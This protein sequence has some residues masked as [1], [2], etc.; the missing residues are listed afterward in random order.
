MK[1]ITLYSRS[2]SRVKPPSSSCRASCVTLSSIQMRLTPNPLMSPDTSSGFWHLLGNTS[3]LPPGLADRSSIVPAQQGLP[4]RAGWGF[5]CG[6]GDAVGRHGRFD[7]TATGDDDW[8]ND[9]VHER[10]HP[11]VAADGG[12]AGSAG[13]AQG[14]ADAH[15]SPGRGGQPRPAAPSRNLKVG[16]LAAHKRQQALCDILRTCLSGFNLRC[17]ELAWG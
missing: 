16:R 14:V 3:P 4:T 11:G 7:K 15:D 6:T 9:G 1:E 13:P 12:R 8:R 5:R 2:E 17:H 10:A